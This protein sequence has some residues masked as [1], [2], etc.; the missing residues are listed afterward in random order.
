[1]IPIKKYSIIK[2]KEF[3]NFRLNYSAM[4]DMITISEPHISVSPANMRAFFIDF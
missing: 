3:Q 4:I 2:E 1:M